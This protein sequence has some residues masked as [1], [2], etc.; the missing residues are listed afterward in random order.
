[1]SIQPQN[2]PPA[3]SAGKSDLPAAYRCPRCGEEIS[4]WGPGV[5]EGECVLCGWRG[6]PAIHEKLPADG[7]AN[8]ADD[9]LGREGGATMGTS[10]A[11]KD[12]G[13]H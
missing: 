2:L 13:K 10:K 6:V 12:A 1:M 3:R 5:N 9:G 11:P 4:V 8:G 7:A